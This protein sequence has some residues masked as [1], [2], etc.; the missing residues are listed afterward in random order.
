MKRVFS[1]LLILSLLVVLPAQAETPADPLL[2]QAVALAR[3]LGELAAS[4]DYVAA[5]STSSAISEIIAVWA[6]GDYDAPAAVGRSTLNPDAMATIIAALSRDTQIVG[7]PDAV[8]GEISRRMLSALPSLFAGTAGV[9]SIAAVS[10]MTIQTA[11]VCE[12]CDTPTLYI[13]RYEQGA[14][15]A[16]TFQPCQDGAVL[17][18]ACFLN[19]PAGEGNFNAIAMLSAL[20]LINFEEV[21]LP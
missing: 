2:D 18:Q 1:L 4:E 14:S 21:P 8:Y 20:G 3:R 10:V 5:Y 9:E 16:V 11:F 13:L 17:A 6:E 7:L 15:V 12:A 19:M